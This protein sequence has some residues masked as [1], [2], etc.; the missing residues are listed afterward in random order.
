MFLQLKQQT[1]NLHIQLEETVDI[2][3]RVSSI[4]RHIAVLKI[5]LG[6]YTPVEKQLSAVKG[7]EAVAFDSRRKVPQLRKDL[8]VLG[9]Q[10][11]DIDQL[12]VCA[13]LPR[14][15]NLASALGCMYVFEGATLGGQIISRHLKKMGIDPATGAAFFNSYGD[16][17]GAMWLAFKKDAEQ[18]IHNVEAETIVIG[19]AQETFGKLINWF[20][21][22][23]E[24]QRND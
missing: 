7:I 14:I 18:H 15:V 8:Q 9:L 22:C 19:T 6:F 16:N 17:V 3:S 13:E 11:D 24:D 2:F 5:F 20:E 23:S 1:H 12:P 4:D 10:P 21:S